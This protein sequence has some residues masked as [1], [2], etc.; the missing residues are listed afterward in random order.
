LTLTLLGRF[1]GI[2]ETAGEFTFDVRI[3][4]ANGV[5][6]SKTFELLIEPADVVPPTPTPVVIISDSPLPAAVVGSPYQFLLLAE[7]GTPLYRWLATPPPGLTI[8]SSGLIAG[9]PT[10]PGTYDFK[11]E[12]FDSAQGSASKDFRLVVRPL[13]LTLTSCVTGIEGFVGA[14]YSVACTAAGGTLPYAWSIVPTGAVPGLSINVQGVISGI[15]TAAGSYQFT[16]KVTDASGNESTRDLPLTVTGVPAIDIE[17]IP[18]EAAAAQQIPFVI[19]LARAYPVDITG[20]ATLQ[21][22]QD[23][24]NPAADPAVMFSSGGT[25]VRFTIPAGTTRLTLPGF[26]T[27]SVAGTFTVTLSGL[28]SGTVAITS[29]PPV[30][31]V[32]VRRGPPRIDSVRIERSGQSV[33]IV[34]TGMSNPRQL[35]R[36]R[37]RFV[38]A[39]N[40]KLQTL[41]VTVEVEAE[42]TRWFRDPA[43]A[44]FGSTFVYR[45]PFTI[46]GDPNAFTNVLVT[47]TNVEGTSEEKGQ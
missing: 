18:A 29:T 41:D 4:D 7:G 19:T 22:A 47:L 38:A 8:N 11:V 42:F 40:A 34:V 23:V 35:T 14:A 30:K 26:Q 10:A 37:F 3:K 1:S 17:G 31:S 5:E 15:P 44:A 36:A 25:T 27:G 13:P 28:Q 6:A 33:V 20:T 16:V 45:Q 43:S 46:Q 21:V 9:T 2:P 12:V 32:R 24:V 39:A